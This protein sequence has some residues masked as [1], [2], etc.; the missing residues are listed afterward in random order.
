M[1]DERPEF[2]RL[3]HWVPDVPE[4]V[5]RYTEAGF[6]AHTNEPFDGFRNGAWRLDER[7]VEILTVFDEAA[8]DT[9]VFGRALR[10]LRPAVEDVAARGGGAM[11]FAVNVTDA[12][13]SAQRLR[14]QG[15]R[16]EEVV[17]SP[18]GRDVSFREVFL[19]DAPSGR[20]SSSRTTR[21]V[22]SSSPSTSRAA[23]RRAPTTSGRSSSR[24]PTRSTPP[25]GSAPFWISRPRPPRSCSRV[26]ASA[27]REVRRTAS[28]PSSPRARKPRSTA[29]TS[30]PSEARPKSPNVITLDSSATK[31]DSWALVLTQ[32]LARVLL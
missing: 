17:A 20:P 7:Y 28:S 19:P 4:A 12:A 9:G 5:R 18:E 16:V 3:L 29:W 11:T 31:S 22:S 14:L 8:Y 32:A 24:P 25:A 1:S 13:A 21:P 27:S 6:P 23:S 2:D 10:V 15:H 26:A 30:G